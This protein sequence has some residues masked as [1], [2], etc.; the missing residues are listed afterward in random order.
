VGPADGD[1]GRAAPFLAL[2]GSWQPG[3]GG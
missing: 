1:A 3:M 2:F